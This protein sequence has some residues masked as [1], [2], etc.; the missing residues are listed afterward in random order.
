MALPQPILELFQQAS[1]TSASSRMNSDTFW[2]VFTILILVTSFFVR[3]FAVILA[4]MAGNYVGDKLRAQ[5]TGQRGH[6]LEFIHRDEHGNTFIAANLLLSNFLPALMISLLA[7][8]RM[9]YSFLGGVV[10]SFLLGDRYED[11]MWHQLDELISGG[12]PTH[13]WNPAEHHLN[14]PPGHH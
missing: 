2:G 9:V 14:P 3:I 5:V 8:P 10:T 1:K 6:Q 12:D 11:E 4:A 7:K 13:N